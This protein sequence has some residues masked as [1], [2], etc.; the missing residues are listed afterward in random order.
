MEQKIQVK[1]L[2]DG[3]N[4]R[5]GEK[6][7]KINE[8]KNVLGLEPSNFEKYIKAICRQQETAETTF[9]IAFVGMFNSGKSTVINSFLGLTSNKKL[10]HEIDPDTAK[11]IRLMYKSSDIDYDAEVIFSDGTKIKTS[12]DEAKKYTSQVYLDEHSEFNKKAVSVIEIIYYLEHDFLSKCNL[13]DLPGTGT[14]NWSTHTKTTHER[15]L[16]AEVIFWVIGTCEAEPSGSDL[17]DLK[18]L[19]DVKSNVIP[20]INVWSDEEEGIG[21]QVPPEEMEA[22]IRNSLSSFFASDAPILKYY[23]REIEKARE[24]DRE[25]KKEWGMKDFMEFLQKQFLDDEDSKAREKVRRICG[26][27]S[28][29]LNHIFDYVEG[30]ITKLQIIK[31]QMSEKKELLEEQKEDRLNIR[32]EVKSQLRDVAADRADTIVKQCISSAETFIEDKMKMTNFSLLKESIKTRDKKVI[33]ARLG[34]DFKDNYLLLREQ[35]NWLTYLFKDYL[36]DAGIIVEAKWRRFIKD[37]NEKYSYHQE[38]NKGFIPTDFTDN[39]LD[40]V[41]GSLLAKLLELLVGGTGVFLLVF[42]IPGGQIIDAA[43]VIVMVLQNIYSDPLAKHRKNAMKR[44]KVMITNQRY[45]LKNQLALVGL[46]LHDK[47]DEQFDAII[48]ANG[49]EMDK[50]QEAYQEIKAALF[51]VKNIINETLSDIKQLEEG[52]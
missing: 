7:K 41:M 47:F 11:S 30:D 31:S 8:L 34:E 14:K 18:L 44:A 46:D 20:L 22:T 36:E 3:V 16:E 15:L 29:S 17:H 26:S 10:S 50:K 5:L 38:D 48:K 39:I 40:N 28:S 25:L 6:L 21:S 43:L 33:A 32:H 45:E 4:S 2:L 13:L 19:R 51:E 27:V 52:V 23:A 24:S 37:F 35:P 1:P 12:W 49:L 9:T 42:M